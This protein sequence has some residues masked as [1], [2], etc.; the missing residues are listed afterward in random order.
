[1]IS[2]QGAMRKVLMR[3]VLTKKILLLENTKTLHYNKPNLTQPN[4][5]IHSYVLYALVGQPYDCGGLSAVCL[6][7]FSAGLYMLG[8]F[9]RS[10]LT[11]ASNLSVTQPKD[12]LINCTKESTMV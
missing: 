8:L 3:K 4:H 1:M 5:S 12:H 11:D 6:G 2:L 9:S 7:H 10:H